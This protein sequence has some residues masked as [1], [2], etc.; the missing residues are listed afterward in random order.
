MTDTDVLVPRRHKSKDYRK[1]ALEAA[2]ASIAK[3]T[4]AHAAT[5]QAIDA[6]HDA[7]DVITAAQADHRRAL[8]DVADRT[9]DLID[10]IGLAEA[11][12]R[13]GMTPGQ[14]RGLC[15]RST[16]KTA[17]AAPAATG[18]SHRGE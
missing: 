9:T 8:D 12:A 2:Q 5:L 4:A 16:A 14:V 15:R 7:A 17:E 13:L 3:Q 1:I 18:P 11:A 10:L 6:A